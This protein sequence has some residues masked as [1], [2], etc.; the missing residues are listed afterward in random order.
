LSIET[1]FDVTRPLRFRGKV[2]LLEPLCQKNRVAVA[3]VFGCSV[4]LDLT[5]YIDRMIYLG[6]YEPVNTVLFDRILKPGMTVVDVGANI[7]YFTFLAAKKVGSV[8]KVVSVEPHPSNFALLKDAIESNQILNVRALPIALGDRKD[9]IHIGM[10]DQTVFPNRTASTLKASVT[11]PEISVETLDDLAEKEG[12]RTIDLLKIDVDG[13]EWRI[14][15]G[16]TNC[17][18]EKRVK[19]IIIE[20]NSYWLKESGTSAEELRRLLEGHGFHDLS[21]RFALVSFFLGRSGD[22]YFALNE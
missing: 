13:Y 16:A 11:D 17:L 9:R 19:R 6:C 1:F 22:R 2:R 18:Q 4:K 3:N 8:G 12:L 10:A 21:D 5:N 15:Q 7:G 20:F 14:L